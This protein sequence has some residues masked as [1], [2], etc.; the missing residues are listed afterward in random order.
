MDNSP[1]TSPLV[2]SATYVVFTVDNQE[3][4]LAVPHINEI[5]PIV[6]THPVAEAP[7]WLVG[8]MD[9]RG[10]LTPVIDL[11]RR[12]GRRPRPAQLDT[13]II[14]VEHDGRLVGLIVDTV[15]AVLTIPDT[16][17]SLPDHLTGADHPFR[18]IARLENRLILLFDSQRLSDDLTDW[19]LPDN[20]ADWLSPEEDQP[21]REG[22]D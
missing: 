22:G 6:A 21:V 20:L 3:Y 16:A 1:T 10:R 9:L 7:D 13:P 11:R 2:E 12:L 5:I 4:G 17:V 19:P 18:A 8:L 15:D 14:V